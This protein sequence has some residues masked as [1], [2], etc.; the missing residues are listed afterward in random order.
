MR[1]SASST[2]STTLLLLLVLFTVA[3]ALIAVTGSL[4]RSPRGVEERFD[5][6]ASQSSSDLRVDQLLTPDGAELA[7]TSTSAFPPAM[8]VSTD[9]GRTCLAFHGADQDV[10]AEPCDKRDRTQRWRYDGV[11][12]GLV[13]LA[14]PEQCMDAWGGEARSGVPIKTHTCH[15]RGN[16]RW[17]VVGNEVRNSETGKCLD[18]QGGFREGEVVRGKKLI[19]YH[20]NRGRNQQFVVGSRVPAAAPP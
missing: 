6:P 7:Y 17:D 12:R 19:A 20:C 5:D 9:A 13:S 8:A 14:A 16:Q 2:S 10:T 1:S 11:T 18:I 3:L 15:G 4:S